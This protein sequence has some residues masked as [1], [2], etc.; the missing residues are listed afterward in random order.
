MH[1][2]SPPPNWNQDVTFTDAGPV[3]SPP[4]PPPPGAPYGAPF[5]P[6]PGFAGDAYGAYGG[7]GGFA[8]G[9]G[10]PAPF[11]A[12]PPQ[13]PRTDPSNAYGP[14][15]VNYGA[16]PHIPP[17]PGQ[18]GYDPYAQGFPPGGYAGADPASGVPAQPP[19][20]PVAPPAPTG[21][22][23]T[24]KILSGLA[25]VGI[26]GAVGYGLYRVENPSSDEGDEGSDDD[27]DDDL[28][29]DD[30]GVEDADDMFASVRNASKNAV[31]DE[32]H[33]REVKAGKD[34][35]ERTP[36][37]SAVFQA[38]GYGRAD[39]TGLDAW[40]FG[41]ASHPRNRSKSTRRRR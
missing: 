2:P 5:G 9:F 22:S 6:P 15:A 30:E 7:Q 1:T 41:P 26:V 12:P 23:L 36:K 16:Q 35:L 21:P 38:N 10:A 32:E 8:G 20:E 4:Q 14:R 19:S 24:T 28:E 25:L 27:E 33:Q 34:Q 29:D 40:G 3:A 39:G 37:P 11:Q 18:Q 17:F 13:D 31:E